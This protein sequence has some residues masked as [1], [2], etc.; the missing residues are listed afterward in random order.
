MA[1]FGED[2]VKL[3][4]S[5]W[6]QPEPLII[7]HPKPQ[8]LEVCK[9][10][11]R[12]GYAL[13][14]YAAG[15]AIWYGAV[16]PWLSGVAQ[17]FDF[18]L[19]EWPPE[20]VIGVMYLAWWAV[21]WFWPV[22]ILLDVARRLKTVLVGEVFTF[23]ADSG[24]MEKDGHPVA[25]FRDVSSVQILTVLNREG[26]ALHELG[27]KLNDEKGIPLAKTSNPDEASALAQEIARHLRVPVTNPSVRE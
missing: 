20:D 23:N 7:K 18:G 13:V 3:F 21:V 19:P 6:W 17:Q 26:G 2:W 27:L 11:L 4:R 25:R 9:P 15:L 14:V 16:T 24:T 10:R 5:P 1:A 12:S 8:L 22:A